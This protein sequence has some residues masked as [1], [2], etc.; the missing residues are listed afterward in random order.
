M[1]RGA[2]DLMLLVAAKLGVGLAVLATGFRA[3]S[4]D[5]FARVVLSQRW[6]ED[7]RLDPTGT[8]WLP[9]PFWIHGGVMRVF[10][11][12][13]DVA[14]V[15]AVVLG[16]AAVVLL[17]AAGRVWWRDRRDAWWGALVGAVFPWSAYLG[18]ATVPELPTAAATVFGIAT[19]GATRP[20]V[21]AVGALAL[22]AACLC[23]YEPWPA[24]ALF[25]AW[26]LVDLVRAP[27]PKERVRWFGVMAL[28][29][30]GPAMWLTFNAWAHGDPLHFAARVSA[31]QRAVGG[32][33]SLFTY[34]SA[35]AREEPELM[36]FGVVVAGYRSRQDEMRRRGPASRRV[37]LTLGGTLLALSLASLPGSAPT[38]HSGRAVLA[39]WL[40]LALYIAPSSRRALRGPRRRVVALAGLAVIVLGATVLR[41]WY[42]RRDRFTPRTAEVAVGVATRN[43]PGPVLVEVVDYRFYAIEAGSGAPGRF[44]RDRTIDPRGPVPANAFSSPAH[45]RRRIVETGARAVVGTRAAIRR[46]ELGPPVATHGD[47]MLVVVAGP[48]P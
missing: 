21:R 8:S 17:Y 4:D 7:P 29:A 9:L 14:R 33:R 39:V 43:G 3:V 13:L 45:L 22:S 10:G 36:A 46:A 24:T 18:V 1:R 6:A 42:A 28:A 5:D 26:T 31:Y 44:I 35:L 12:S 11:P 20:A 23:R 38:H 47:W 48:H 2:R 19:L 32:P 34:V 15:T 27:E 25:G 40:G 37:G 41:P 16:V 30:L